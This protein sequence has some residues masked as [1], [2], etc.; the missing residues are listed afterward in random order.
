LGWRDRDWAR[1]D[2]SEQEV[3]FGAR[4]MRQTTTRR[5]WLRGFIGACLAVAALCAAAGQLPRHH[6]LV[7]EFAFTLPNLSGSSSTIASA[8]FGHGRTLPLGGP[9]VARRGG[10]YSFGGETGGVGGL[11]LA[12]A[13]VARGRW[14]GSEWRVLAR[15][16]ADDRGRYSITVFL[17]RAG[18]L[19][20]RIST[21]DGF[22]GTKTIRVT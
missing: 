10:T 21:P 3:L 20:L 19:D 16:T 2:T 9:S 8:A 15:T 14:N 6:P 13:V 5:Q 12:G 22:V 4:S 11:R 17:D 1:L 7:P 18:V